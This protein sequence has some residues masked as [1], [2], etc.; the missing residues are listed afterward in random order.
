MLGDLHCKAL[1]VERIPADA[2]TSKR[3]KG[4]R[5]GPVG[6]GQRVRRVRWPLINSS[7]PRRSPLVRRLFYL[8]GTRLPTFSRPPLAHP[9]PLYPPT[10]LLTRYFVSC[11]TLYVLALADH[12][13]RM[14]A[15]SRR[16]LGLHFLS[17]SRSLFYR[18]R[19]RRT[20]TNSA[21]REET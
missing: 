11:F 13:D 7:A 15:G 20:R 14:N 10:L 1:P 4:P 16:F 9:S 18:V 12:H 3:G 2:V 17:A 5:G 6:K 21:V 8:L 19:V